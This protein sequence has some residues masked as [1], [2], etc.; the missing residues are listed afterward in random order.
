MEKVDDDL[1]Q[2]ER[3]SKTKD[4]FDHYYEDELKQKVSVLEK[5]RQ[6]TM[7]L[8]TKAAIKLAIPSVIAIILYFIFGGYL[9][10]AIPILAVYGRFLFKDVKA[11]RKKLLEKL[12]KEV[13]TDLVYFMNPNFRYRPKEYLSS[14]KFR[15]ANIFKQKP[16]RYKGSD[17]IKGYV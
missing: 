4:E 6:K 13:V 9:L 10:L 1:Y 17:L 8:A 3:F 7:K 14:T 15:I 16:N 12:K 5:E 2:L 11:K